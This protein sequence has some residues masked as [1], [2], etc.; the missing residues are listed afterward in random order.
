MCV[1]V[2]VCSRH[3][4][5]NYVCPIFQYALNGD[6]S[7][8]TAAISAATHPWITKSAATFSHAFSDAAVYG[9]V[10]MLTLGQR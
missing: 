9:Y 5:P 7:I 3:N 6:G 2:C 8:A 4:G 10:V 1:T